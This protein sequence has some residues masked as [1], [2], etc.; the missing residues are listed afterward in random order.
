MIHYTL[1]S[2][3]LNKNIFGGS[4]AEIR[5]IGTVTK[6]DIVLSKDTVV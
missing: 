2:F 5:D 3:E 1:I 6:C 4:S